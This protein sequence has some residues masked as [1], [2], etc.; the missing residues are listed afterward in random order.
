MKTDRTA[1]PRRHFLKTLAAA[2]AAAAAAPLTGLAASAVT[3]RGIK[4]GYDNFSIR[5]LNWMVEEHIA[6]SVKLGCD[7]L[8]M[9]DLEHFKSLDEAYLRDVRQ[10]ATD[11]GL[12]LHAGTWSICPTSKSFR[13]KWGTAEEHLRLAIRVAQ[14]LGSPVIRVILGDGGDRKTEGGIQARIKDTAKVCRA[15]RTQALDAGVKIAVENHAGDL[16][17]GEMI[18]LIEE[19][20]G[21]DYVGVTLDAGNATWTMEHPL[22]LLEA[23]GPYILTSAIR[24]SAVWPS[25]NGLTVQWTAVGEGMVDWKAYF[26]RFAQLCPGV[27]IHIETISGFNREFPYFRAEFWEAFP[28]MKA[29]DF[30]RF[31]AWARSGRPRDPWRA[32][33]G[34]PRAEAEQAYQLADLERSIRFCKAQGI[35]L[36]A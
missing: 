24:D 23:L 6:H 30:A 29:A 3:R 18:T 2:G 21:R 17:A 20:G 33:A 25:D 35:G 1:Q 27:P 13:D 12:Q 15:C 14:A 36:K 28:D 19:A 4:L 32:P 16:L 7:S 11:Q 31:V 22:D 10:L 34:Q 5:A 26:D 9:T 8:F